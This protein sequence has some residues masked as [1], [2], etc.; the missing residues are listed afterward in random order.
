MTDEGMFTWM[1]QLMADAQ[2]EIVPDGVIFDD[3]NM[4]ISKHD[5]DVRMTCKRPITVHGAIPP[6][7]P[8]SKTIH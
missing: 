5:G 7:V 8:T 4:T 6:P 3:D 2:S 1:L